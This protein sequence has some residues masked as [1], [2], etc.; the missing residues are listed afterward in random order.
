MA[1]VESLQDAVRVLVAER[2]ALHER[3]AAHGELEANRVEL[4]AR[5]Q[6][7]SEALIARHLPRA[8]RNAA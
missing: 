6:Q 2:Q 1:S 3:R 5:Q 8:D 4:V 7:L